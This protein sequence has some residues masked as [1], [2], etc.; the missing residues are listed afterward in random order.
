[1][2][3]RAYF[4]FAWQRNHSDRFTYHTMHIRRS[5]DLLYNQNLFYNNNDKLLGIS[6]IYPPPKRVFF[7]IHYLKKQ[8]YQLKIIY[9]ATISPSLNGEIQFIFSFKPKLI[10]KF[11]KEL[12]FITLHRRH[13]ELF[14]E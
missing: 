11:W 3:A 7:Y 10:T 4:C 9:I 12:L 14:K 13:K 1:M 6:N 8:K 5:L 2:N